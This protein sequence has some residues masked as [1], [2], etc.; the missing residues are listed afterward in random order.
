MI[1]NGENCSKYIY[2]S[3]CVKNNLLR[4][5]FCV[6]K[7]TFEN[8]VEILW[9]SPKRVTYSLTNNISHDHICYSMC[10][11]NMLI[12]VTTCIIVHDVLVFYGLRSPR[13]LNKLFYIATRKPLRG[14]VYNLSLTFDNKRTIWGAAKNPSRGLSTRLA[15][16]LSAPRC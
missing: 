5:H 14:E 11:V 13:K 10:N 8:I 2:L 7:Q 9:K 16:L 15:K 1:I 12:I 3:I 6:I 4:A